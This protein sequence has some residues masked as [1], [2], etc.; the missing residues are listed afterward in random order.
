M[1]M[2]FLTLVNQRSSSQSINGQSLLMVNPW[3]TSWVVNSSSTGVGGGWQICNR[4]NTRHMATAVN[5]SGMQL[6]RIGNPP[7]IGQLVNHWST[8]VVFLSGR[9][10]NAVIDCWSASCHSI[11]KTVVCHWSA[12]ALAIRVYRNPD[13]PLT[14]ETVCSSAFFLSVAMLDPRQMSLM[15]CIPQVVI[16]GGGGGCRC[17]ALR[18][19]SQFAAMQ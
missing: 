12:R 2:Q 3:V 14:A 7:Q 16:D 6:I 5:P 9:L 17:P 13:M 4:Y 15:S 19:D 18:G 10:V 8:I 11:L 1:Y